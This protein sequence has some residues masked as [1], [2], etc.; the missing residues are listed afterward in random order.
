MSANDR[1][2]GG[3]HYSG[4]YQHWDLAQDLGFSY[5]IGCITKYVTRFNRKNGA[6][7]I[8]KSIHYVEKQLEVILNSKVKYV[9]SVLP[10]RLQ[11]MDMPNQMRLYTAEF[12]TSKVEEF[13]R[14][15]FPNADRCD[16]EALAQSTFAILC[17]PYTQEVLDSQEFEDK[18]EIVLTAAIPKLQ[19]LAS[20][21]KQ[22]EDEGAEPTSAYVNQG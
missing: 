21:I 9:N 18:I 8:T 20:L 15:T 22:S 1:Q 13:L 17:L 4:L 19:S 12:R 5:L 11:A 16:K 2:V 10:I 6:E 14:V 7:D 3:A